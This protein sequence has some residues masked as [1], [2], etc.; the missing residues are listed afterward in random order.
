MTRRVQME[1]LNPGLNVGIVCV[2]IWCLFR[3]KLESIRCLSSS[4]P[5]TCVTQ[6]S[7]HNTIHVPAHRPCQ[8]L[9]FLLMRKKR[10]ILALY[11]PHKK[12]K[13][14][15]Q[16]PWYIGWISFLVKYLYFFLTFSG[17]VIMGVRVRTLTVTQPPTPLCDQWWCN[18]NPT[19][20]TV[21]WFLHPPPPP[22]PS[23]TISL[24]S[25]PFVF[26]VWL[27]FFYFHHWKL[28]R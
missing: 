16:I 12:T 8:A 18:C 4:N 5:S 2:S 10:I 15:K 23:P 28:R 22:P 6:S 14:K 20:Q 26:L 3:V 13:K 21:V 24:L 17:Y 27:W 11:S 9:Y 7:K 1:L 19:K 25:C